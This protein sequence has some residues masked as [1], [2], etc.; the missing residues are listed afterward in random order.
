MYS[1]ALQP[2]RATAWTVRESIRWLPAPVCASVLEKLQNSTARHAAG[3]ARSMRSHWAASSISTLRQIF[4]AVVEA[5]PSLAQPNELT[6]QV[7]NRRVPQ[8]H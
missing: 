8:V 1:E 5:R 7:E 3:S 2:G 6:I 4:A